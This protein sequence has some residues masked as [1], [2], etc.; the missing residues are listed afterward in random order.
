MMLTFIL[1]LI[2]MP[3]RIA[4]MSVQSD[5]LNAKLDALGSG[6]D[7]VQAAL[8]GPTGIR[9][10]IAD[11]RALLNPGGM[12]ADE[13]TAALAKTDAIQAKLDAVVAD[14]QELDAENPAPTPPTT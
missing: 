2:L 7:A 3:G 5:A 4:A 11:L 14:V 1:N 9:Q 12:T 13:V 10:D 8:S 6:I